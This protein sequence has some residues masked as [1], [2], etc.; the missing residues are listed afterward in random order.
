MPVYPGALPGTNWAGEALA[1]VTLTSFFTRSNVPV[2]AAQSR[3]V[4]WE[5]LREQNVILLGHADSNHWI[6]RVLHSA[7]FSL[8]TTDHLRRARI[9][10]SRP[11]PGEQAEYFPTLPEPPKSYALVSMLAGLDG[12][13]QILVIGQRIAQGRIHHFDLSQCE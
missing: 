12:A 7:P 4:T 5:A 1:A 6:Q 8:A 2:K 9:V 13:H 10:N 3:F 11:Q